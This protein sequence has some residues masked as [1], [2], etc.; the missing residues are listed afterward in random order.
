MKVILGSASEPIEGL[1]YHRCQ[2]NHVD[3]IRANPTV[4]NPCIQQSI[5]D[6]QGQSS[7][8]SQVSPAKDAGIDIALSHDHF[9]VELWEIMTLVALSFSVLKP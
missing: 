1:R 2:K 7:Q 9:R 6:P 3:S 8:V 4:G 5:Q